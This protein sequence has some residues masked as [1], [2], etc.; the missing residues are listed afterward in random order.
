MW[1]MFANE[2]RN[3]ARTCAIDR[4]EVHQASSCSAR[5]PAGISNVLVSCDL[6]QPPY[7]VAGGAEAID[8]AQIRMG[9]LGL[10][11]ADS[12]QV[13]AEMLYWVEKRRNISGVQVA[14]Y[15]LEWREKHVDSSGFLNPTY[16]NERCRALH[17]SS[18]GIDTGQR[19]RLASV[20]L[21]TNGDHAD[22]LETRTSHLH[23]LLAP[24]T[25][26]TITTNVSNCRALD[27]P[28]GANGLPIDEQ[29]LCLLGEYYYTS[30][31]FGQHCDARV[32][33]SEMALP[34][35]VSI[36]AGVRTREAG[37]RRSGPN[38][39]ALAEAWSLP[40]GMLKGCGVGW[41]SS[42]G[43]GDFLVARDGGG[44]TLAESTDALQAAATSTLWLWRIFLSLVLWFLAYIMLTNAVAP[45]NRIA[46]HIPVFGNRLVRIVD[47]AVCSASFTLA[48][49]LSLATMAL[50]WLLVRPI[51]AL[52]FALGVLLAAGL[53]FRYI[54]QR[55]DAAEKHS[56]NKG[57]QNPEDDP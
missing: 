7:Y 20:L 45:L 14:F 34:T 52:L 24:I 9:P 19:Y 42:L 32:Q 31:P 25:I 51:K 1:S 37:N 50:S 40:R 21:G 38:L 35:Q 15:D 57:E 48:L 41:Y 53:F 16:S 49:T 36:L 43:D 10:S 4:L 23:E 33:V 6:A 22:L 11:E 46:A 55:Q 44:M 39:P 54:L 28:L 18:R 8:G 12:V 3:V 2:A 29:G 5:L 26:R 17:P 27:S 30:Y 56:N 47:S 13:T